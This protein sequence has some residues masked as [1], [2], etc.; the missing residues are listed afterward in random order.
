MATRYLGLLIIL[1]MLAV[2]HAEQ[3]MT[4][5]ILVTNQGA[6][7]GKD[8]PLKNSFSGSA[9]PKSLTAN[10][11]RQF[12][13]LGTQIRKDY[14]F[15]QAVATSKTVFMSASP[16]ASAQAATAFAQ[17]FW[18]KNQGVKLP[19]GPAE[20]FSKPPVPELDV[21]IDSDFAL[22]EGIYTPTTMQLSSQFDNLF[23]PD[24][25]SVCPAAFRLVSKSI[26]EDLKSMEPDI[27][28]MSS[29]L[30][31][32]GMSPKSLFHQPTFSAAAI[33]SLGHAFT[34]CKQYDG[35]DCQ[36]DSIVL[37]ASLVD[38]VRRFAVFYDYKMAA[39]EPN[40]HRLMTH[41]LGQT[42]SDLLEDDGVSLAVLSGTRQTLTVLLSAWGVLS[43]SCMHK[44]VIGKDLPAQECSVSVPSS[45]S[46]L[47]LE[48]LNDPATNSKHVRVLLDNKP[49]VL[50]GANTTCSFEEFDA[51]FDGQLS[52]V[53]DYNKYCGNPYLGEV[54]N[55]GAIV[56]SSKFWVLTA[57]FAVGGLGLL[58]TWMWKRCAPR[59]PK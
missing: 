41:R 36:L 4:K 5:L 30:Q 15:L 56:E 51:L 55:G 28:S 53:G 13:L 33:A 18:E 52:F 48:V 34:A 26:L 17:G 20:A 59:S 54:K 39:V 47:A 23:F 2:T 46:V 32:L 40:V 12:A 42:L 31:K 38:R 29:A 9:V 14:A 1:G 19:K 35:S 27:S 24:L 45:A 16:P 11:L 37:E 22:P 6:N 49:I 57:G 7:N 44:W 58:L 50:C 10:G 8:L 43:S 3:Q 21:S 25:Q